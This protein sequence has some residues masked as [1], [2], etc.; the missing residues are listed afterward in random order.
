MMPP[1][2]STVALTGLVVVLVAQTLLWL[3]SLRLRDASIVDPFWGPGFALATLAYYVADGRHTPRGTLALVLV[4]LWAARLGLHLLVR[5]R[6][7]GE[8]ARY[9]AMRERHGE[10]F[11]RVSLVRVFWLQGVILWI[12]SAPL[13]TA[14]RSSRPLGLWDALG[15]AVFLAGLACEALADRQLRRFKADPSNAGRVLDTGLWRYSRHP[16]YFGD[17]TVWW[18][19]WI[20]AAA[21]RGWWTVFGPVAMTFLLLRVSGVPL[22]EK[23]LER[24]RPGYPEYVR[25]TSAF[26]PWWPKR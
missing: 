9:A 6:R 4:T 10:R 24:S 16:N 1:S 18:G 21:G 11:G 3:L 5:N 25:R 22:L 15:S 7:S 26:V 17:A 2:F 20:V 8:D 23:G 19:L 13:L 12:I 14:V